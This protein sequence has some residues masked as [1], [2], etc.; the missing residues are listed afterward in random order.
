M[1]RPPAPA[2]LQKHKNSSPETQGA[3]Q[4]PENKW[5]SQGLKVPTYHKCLFMDISYK[6]E[7]LWDII[8]RPVSLQLFKLLVGDV[9]PAPQTFSALA[10]PLFLTELRKERSF[11]HP[12]PTTPRTLDCPRKSWRVIKGKAAHPSLPGLFHPSLCKGCAKA[13]L[14]WAGM[15]SY[16]PNHPYF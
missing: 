2:I 4:L 12:F 9:S 7:G 11:H 15:W 8:I 6:N 13:G 14:P 1:P 3:F 16:S 10:I 5:Q